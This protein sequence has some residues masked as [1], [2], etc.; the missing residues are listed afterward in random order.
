MAAF[1]PAAFLSYAHFDNQAAKGRIIDLADQL[2]CKVQERT[3]EEFRVFYDRNVVEWG[4]NWRARVEGALGTVT[5]LIPVFTQQYFNSIECLRELLLFTRNRGKFG[6]ENLILPLYYDSFDLLEIANKRKTAGLSAQIGRV[7]RE[8]ATPQE[9]EE[10]AQ[11]VGQ[12]QYDDWRHLHDQDLQAAPVRVKVAELADRIS[13]VLKAQD[14]IDVVI[15]VGP[16]NVDRMKM[17]NCSGIKLLSYAGNR[18]IWQHV[19]GHLARFG[20]RIRCIYLLMS[21]AKDSQ[22]WKLT[23]NCLVNRPTGDP[24]LWSKIEMIPSGGDP[25]LFP[26]LGLETLNLTPWFLLHYSDVW[27]EEGSSLYQDLLAKKADVQGSCMGIL[28]CSDSAPQGFLAPRAS[29]AAEV[30]SISMVAKPFHVLEVQRLDNLRPRFANMAIALLR[31]EIL[32]TVKD[33][34]LKGELF[35][36]VSELCSQGSKFEPLVHRGVW[37]HCDTESDCRIMQQG[38]EYA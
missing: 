25:D 2:A 36:I 15:P 8:E 28:A 16:L 22:E 29:L 38:S 24:N 18:P 1:I 19:F 7:L 17:P 13:A 33:R 5:I 3:G 34:E 35:N 6:L 32:T 11:L 23:E 37:Y 20:H 14:K 9:C 12:C 4:D 31:T 27:P 30:S 21:V 26:M 10:L